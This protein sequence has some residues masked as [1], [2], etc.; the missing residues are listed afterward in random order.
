MSNPMKS[1]MVILGILIFHSFIFVTLAMPLSEALEK[2]LVSIEI[3]HNSTG[4]HYSSPLVLNIQNKVNRSLQIE[5]DN[6]YVLIPADSAEQKMIVTNDLLVKL[7]PNESKAAHINA[8]CLEQYDRA[9][10]EESSYFLAGLAGNNLRKLSTFIQ[11][12]EQYEP[13]AQ[14]LMWEL[15][16]GAYKSEDIDKFELSEDGEVWVRNQEGVELE[17]IIEYADIEEPQRQLLVNGEFEMNF[18]REKN[19]HIAMF[20]ENKVIVKELFKN[21]KTPI[22]KTKLEYAFNS[23]EYEEEVYFVKLVVDG[24]IIMT[25]TIEMQF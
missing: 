2:D 20:N 12:N 16:E 10:G 9:P 17:R 18:S 11:E 14:F 15:A 13:A 4:T 19:V 3:T 6:G 1:V 5:L 8:M 21:P 25:R 24:E 23:L 22:G 7:Y